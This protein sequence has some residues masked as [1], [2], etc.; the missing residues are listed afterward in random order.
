VYFCATALSTSDAVPEI[1]NM[2]RMRTLTLAIAAT[3]CLSWQP[4]ASQAAIP[5]V[6]DDREL[7]SLAPMLERT[8]PGVVNIATRSRVQLRENPLL[9][10]PFFRYFFGIPP[11]QTRP[12][13]RQTSSLGSGVVVDAERG[14]I[15]TNHHVIARADEIAVTLRDGRTL[16]A[17]LVGSD[18]EVDVAVIK[19]PA[20][21]LT[22]IAVGDS[23][24]LRVGD[25]VVAIGNP[26]GLGQTVTSGIVS[27]LS[28]SG[29]GI[30]DFE[31]FI[32]TDASINPGNSGGALV[33]LR[34]NLVGINTAIA[35]PGNGGNVGIGFAI[36]SKLAMRIMAQIV[37]HGEVRRGG[38]GIAVQNLTPELANAFG[39][40]VAQGVV[41]A[42]VEPGSA[43][44]SAGLRAGDV[45]TAVDGRAV[46]DSDDLRNTLGLVGVGDRVNLR[47]VRGERALQLSA[48]VAETLSD[49]LDGGSVHPRL[50]GAS[51]SEIDPNHPLYGRVEGVM[52]SALE[53]GTSAAVTGIRPGDIITSVNRQGVST[54]REFTEAARGAGG[55][56]LMNIQRGTGAL[57]L[58]IQ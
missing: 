48:I 14:Y 11:G 39:L 47:I 16:Q 24:R 54:L 7:P 53:P 18:P 49:S 37:E 42:R 35:S 27:A 58:V 29:L 4:Q 38:L 5:A 13:E 12:R 23:E 51:F 52:V 55:R 6:V 2:A 41:V 28:R 19:V 1:D 3:F 22:A 44:E 43:A 10:D 25:F 40:R 32:Q 21:N 31:D 8:T 36:P 15:L 50:E 46:R 26:Y 56:L 17:E 57:F 34:G 45:I 20:E 30:E 33:D 9:Q